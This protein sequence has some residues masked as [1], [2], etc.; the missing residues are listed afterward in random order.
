MCLKLFSSDYLELGGGQLVTDDFLS[1]VP[2]VTLAKA[3]PSESLLRFGHIDELKQPHSYRSLYA[4]CSCRLRYDLS[5][6]YTREF[7]ARSYRQAGYSH[8]CSC[9]ELFDYS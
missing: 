2:S 5:N 4:L 8:S 9:A 6:Q 3:G 7:C 1:A